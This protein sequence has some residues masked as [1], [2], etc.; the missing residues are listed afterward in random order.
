[1]AKLKICT[2]LILILLFLV[3]NSCEKNAGLNIIET[4]PTKSIKPFQKAWARKPATKWIEVKADKKG[5]LVYKP[6]DGNTFSIDIKYQTDVAEIRY[7]IESIFVRYDYITTVNNDD[8]FFV[9]LSNEGKE[10]LQFKINE[11]DGKNQIV[12]LKLENK[13]YLMTPYKNKDFFRKIEN[14]CE[15]GKV[16][17][18]EFLPI[19]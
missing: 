19:N 14:K 9:Y 3:L 4:S 2:F 1:M 11:Y 5:Y 8:N 7:P 16:S 10:V 15:N 13:Q 12:L 17:E 6:C 18:L